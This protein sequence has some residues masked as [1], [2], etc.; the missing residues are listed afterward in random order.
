MRLVKGMA[1]ALVFALSPHYKGDTMQILK[2][3][4][5]L[6]TAEDVEASYKVLRLM[7][8]LDVSPSLDAWRTM[9][10]IVSRLNPKVAQVDLNQ[11]LNGTFVRRLEESGF[12]PEMRKRFQ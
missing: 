6:A 9:Q 10:R 7:T 8:T 4:L 12:L 1:E 5:R 11:V 3:N 2:K